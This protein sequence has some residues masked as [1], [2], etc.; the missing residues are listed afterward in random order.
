MPPIVYWLVGL[1]CIAFIC[2]CVADWLEDRPEASLEERVGA[3]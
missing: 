1:A 3:L 2:G